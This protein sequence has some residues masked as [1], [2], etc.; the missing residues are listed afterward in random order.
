MYYVITKGGGR[1]QPNA[2]VCLREG[3]NVLN[4]VLRGHLCFMAFAFHFQMLG[5]FSIF[6]KLSKQGVN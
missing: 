3:H 4:W 1:G 6:V 2:Y 5:Q